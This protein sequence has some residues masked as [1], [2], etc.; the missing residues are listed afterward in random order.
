[1][2]YPLEGFDYFIYYRELPQGIFARVATN[3]DG[4]YSV[5]LDP[6]RSYDQLRADFDHEVRHII[7]NDF[8]NGLPI[9]KVE[10]S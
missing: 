8:Y 3:P 5:Y 9:Q 2:T 7:N 1:M 4:T 6:R 10:A